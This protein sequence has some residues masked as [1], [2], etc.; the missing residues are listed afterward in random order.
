VRAVSFPENPAKLGL[1]SFHSDHW[2]PLLSALEDA[3]L[4]VCLHF[5]TSGQVTITA[6]DAPMAVM[7]TLMGTNSM[8]TVAD[9][10]FSPVFHRHPRIKVAMSEGGTGWIPWLLERAD[11][12]WE[13]HR[14]Y[15]NVNQTVRPSDLFRTHIWGCFIV[16]RYGVDNRHAIGVDRMTWECDYPHS[17]S[18]WPNSRKAVTEMFHDVPDDEVRRIVETNARDLFRF[19]RRP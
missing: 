4:V 11:I 14:Y 19:P 9:L 2:D 15:Q 13:R 1:P 17:D 6:D 16:D 10:L 7:T 12:T 18:F 8:N 5:A 3:Q